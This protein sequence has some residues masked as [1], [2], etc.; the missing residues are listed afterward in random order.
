MVPDIH[1]L[2]SYLSLQVL[3]QHLGDLFLEITEKNFSCAIDK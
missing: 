2:N 3:A 1:F